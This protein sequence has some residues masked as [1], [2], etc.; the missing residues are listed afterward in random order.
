MKH[1]SVIGAGSW[2]TTLALLLANK[3][4]DVTM[5]EFNRDAAEEMQSQREN[6]KF[7]PGAIF[8]DTLNVTND[9]NV[10]I[11]DA[12][13]I[14][15]A[16]PSHVLRSL[17]AQIKPLLTSH[18]IWVSVIKGIEQ[19]TLL[20][21]DEVVCDVLGAQTVVALSGPT[22]AEEVSR[23]IPST[24]VAA[25]PDLKIAQTVQD[26]F[27]T[28]TFKVYTNTDIIGVELGGSLKNVIAL[29]AGI[30][31][32]LGFGDNSKAAVM[33]R[34]LAEITKLGLAAGAQESTFSGL[35]GIGDLITTCISQHSR[36]RH[37]GEELAKGKTLQEIID[38]MHMVA[39]GVNTTR[40]AYALAQKFQINA[41][42]IEEM[43]NVLFHNK[44]PQQAVQDLLNR[45]HASE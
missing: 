9:L 33:T 8:P 3:G 19:E 25:H 28:N 21:V 2:G 10:A 38:S 32:G 20:R 23:Q 30:S 11:S 1:I 44:S 6:I 24:I 42:I 27:T 14:V 12:E 35:S 7:V 15:L 16:V 13:L 18:P 41:P 22:H 34:G 45:P 17:L 40:S 36:N 31:D 43:N 26:A 4:F 29:A 39:E 37:V 5:W